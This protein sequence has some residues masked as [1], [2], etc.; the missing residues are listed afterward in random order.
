MK[1]QLRKIFDNIQYKTGDNEFK[2]EKW[3]Y[4]TE[5]EANRKAKKLRKE[6]YNARV[7]SHIL[8]KDGRG[9]SHREYVIYRRK[10]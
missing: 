9:R 3:Y 1:I 4:S 6:G 10:K 7:W 2:D 5:E 8:Y